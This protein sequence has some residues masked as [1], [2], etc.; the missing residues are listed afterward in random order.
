MDSKD[1]ELS[2]LFARDVVGADIK[3]HEKVVL[4]SN[5]PDLNIEFMKI[6]GASIN[7]HYNGVLKSKDPRYL[8]DFFR[9]LK[10]I[11]SGSVNDHKTY[12]YRY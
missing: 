8:R 3:A 9:E 7:A 10:N 12:K 2:Y 4:D 6:G 5:Q 1:A 11:E